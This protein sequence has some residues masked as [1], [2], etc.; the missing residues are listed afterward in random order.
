MNFQGFFQ[1]STPTMHIH[2]G[3]TLNTYCGEP[4]TL[5][6]NVSWEQAEEAT[7]SGCHAAFFPQQWL[8][9]ADPREREFHTST[10]WGR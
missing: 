7:C 2:Q 6:T 10:Q 3:G 9:T 4:L 5:A 8:T 1:R